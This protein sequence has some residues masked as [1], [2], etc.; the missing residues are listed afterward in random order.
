MNGYFTGQFLVAMPNMG[1]PR[2]ER[3]VVYICAHNEDGA[4]GLVVNQPIEDL[5]LS[6]VLT[7][8]DIGASPGSEHIIVVRGGPVESA[9]GFVLHSPEFVEDG[10]VEVADGICLSSTLD[11][12][13]RIASGDGPTRSL[14]ALGYAGWGPGQ[15]DEE[16]KQNA[17]LTVPGDADLIFA[18]DPDDT[19]DKALG[20]LGISAAL[21]SGEAGRA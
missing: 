4:M 10:T 18:P 7:Q 16:M 19:W 21:L 11:V 20:K 5:H 2:F 6:E 13:K 3:A 17:W 1:D 8:L 15:L 12:L 14:L 9:R